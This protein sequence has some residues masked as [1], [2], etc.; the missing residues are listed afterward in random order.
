[1]INVKKL[2]VRY[3]TDK[4]GKKKEVILPIR[5]FNSLVEDLEDLAVAAERRKEENIPHAEVLKELKKDE[6]L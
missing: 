3:I 5:Q 6:L 1:M 2:N 4:K